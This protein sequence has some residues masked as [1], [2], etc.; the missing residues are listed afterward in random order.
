[1]NP[2]FPSLSQELEATLRRLNPYWRGEPQIQ[3]PPVKRWA[4]SVA[5]KRLKSGL[6]KATVLTGPRQVGKSTLVRQIIQTLL[7]EG[8]EPRRIFYVQ[9]D[10]LRE[11]LRLTEP[12]LTLADW[13]EQYILKESF[14]R[15]TESGQPAYLFFDEVQ[16]LPEWAPQIKSLVDS[17]DVRV[18]VTGSSALRIEQG[19]DSLAG[20]ISTLELG[21]LFL[22]E[23]ME[24]RREE[25]L[26]PFLEFNGI[27]PLRTLD[28]WQDLRAYGEQHR[29]VRLRAFSYFSER[30]AYPIAHN[31]PDV[32]WSE[33]ADQLNETVIR[34]AITHDLRTG[35][36]G[37]KRDQHL[38]EEIFRLV[39]RYA[40]QSPTTSSMVEEIR[41][42]RDA[43]IGTQRV[44]QYL[45][46]L[47]GTLLM[48]LIEP[49]ELRLKRKKGTS[50]I[51]I[52]DHALR[53]SWLQEVVPLSS[54]QLETHSHLKDLAGH[55]A[56]SAAG[57]FLR[58]IVGLDVA[59]FPVRASEPEI[60]YVIT[61]GEQRIPIEI[62]Y[63][64]RINWATDTFGL[65]SFIEKTAYNAPF[66]IMVT[67][68][69]ERPMIGSNI[70]T[71]P[72]STLLMM[73]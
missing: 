4:Y 58:S 38:L 50:K 10:E 35:P 52:C 71:V 11:L 8:V 27:T 63:R 64:S 30:G 54:E 21:T 6:A 23:I 42:T 48:R 1:M 47:D 62:K 51:C 22:R 44:L 60:D 69:E 41:Q 61:V 18:M 7:D 49:L 39:C 68:N 73:R 45:R 5:L 72:L 13:F 33:L 56:E 37:A 70:I 34:R 36:R 12:I 28:F 17:S 40:G 3:L 19:R 65:R 67:L 31:R 46:F 53:A 20:R 66:G 15:A 59:H 16:N 57:Y 32:E 2:I 55:I 9:F 26:Q 24:I 14:N 43:N 29:D 25:T